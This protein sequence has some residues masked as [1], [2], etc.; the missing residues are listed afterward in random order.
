MRG[1]L[2]AALLV[3]LTLGGC[4]VLGLT[5]ATPS[6]T[7]T[8]PAPGSGDSWIVVASGSATP[9]PAVTYPSRATTLPPVA[10]PSASGSACPAPPN[11]QVVIPV[12]V[13]AKVRSLTVSWPRRSASAYRVTAVP[14]RLITGPQ[15]AYSW[16]SV[17]TTGTG[18][19]VTTTITGL[20]SGEPYVVW[21]DAQGTGALTDGTRNP[22]SGA[23]SV[24]YPK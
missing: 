11:G 12:T 16:T 24:V 15:P 5:A 3:P 20:K 4:G 6:P 13:T 8:T 17:P 7:A 22:Y 10:Y 14:Q 21:L 18:C 2:L 19:T 9:S 1:K 23:S